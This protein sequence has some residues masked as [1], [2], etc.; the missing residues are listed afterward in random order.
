MQEKQKREKKYSYFQIVCFVGTILLLI[1][2]LVQIAI[3]VD[4]K[5]KTED[6][7]KKNEEL[8]LPEEPEQAETT[9]FET[10]LKIFD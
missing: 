4:L 3:I 10:S 8:I 9:Y 2:I 7:N 5:N 6:T 1:A